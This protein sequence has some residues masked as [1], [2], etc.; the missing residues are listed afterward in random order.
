MTHWIVKTPG[1]QKGSPAAAEEGGEGRGGGRGEGGRGREKVSVSNDGKL[2]DNFSH[3][4]DI[5]S[6]QDLFTS[7][8]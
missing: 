7:R 4:S 1:F 5:T 3:E 8:P 2:V 6:L